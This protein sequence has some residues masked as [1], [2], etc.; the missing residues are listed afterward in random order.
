MRL[1]LGLA[2]QLVEL[3][4]LPPDPVQQPLRPG[5]MAREDDQADEQEQ[6]ALQDRQEHAEHAE[7][8]ERVAQRLDQDRFHAL[9]TKSCHSASLRT[10]TPSSAAFFAFDPAS[11]PTMI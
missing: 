6:E 8:Q 7:H 11:A 9:P 2:N 4:V 10:V 5:R 3:R 1:A